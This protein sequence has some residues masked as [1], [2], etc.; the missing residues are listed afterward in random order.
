MNKKIIY[1]LLIGTLTFSS[2]SPTFAVIGFTAERQKAKKV[3]KERLVKLNEKREELKKKDAIIA[4]KNDE[5]IS[6][7]NEIASNEQAFK[8]YK[9]L[10]NLKKE[11][12]V[13]IVF[14]QLAI[15]HEKASLGAEKAV[16]VLAQSDIFWQYLIKQSSYALSLF[17]G[18]EDCQTQDLNINKNLDSEAL[19]DDNET[20]RDEHLAKCKEKFIAYAEQEAHRLLSIVNTS[21]AK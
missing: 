2:M 17:Q 21:N 8:K 4:S 9:A 7:N 6:K 19:A 3:A 10:E 15:S 11:K 5:I 20:L 13:G 1:T 16:D 18:V 12:D 14:A